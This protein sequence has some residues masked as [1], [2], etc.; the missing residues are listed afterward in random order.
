MEIKILVVEDDM[1]MRE[2]LDEYLGDNGFTVES[3]GTG[4]EALEKFR[5]SK[6]Q[7]VLLDVVLPDMNGFEV[8]KKMKA[9]SKTVKIIVYTGKV[10]AVDAAQAR[11]AGADDFVVKT[12]D[13]SYVIESVRNLLKKK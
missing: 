7:L 3:V 10:D 2:L 4:K 12:Q 1:E 5:S 9:L 13:L 11:K 6:P 8:C